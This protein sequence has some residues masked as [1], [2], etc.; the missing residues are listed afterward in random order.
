MVSIIVRR[1]DDG[2]VAS[3]DRLESDGGGAGGGRGDT[4]TLEGV[5]NWLVKYTRVRW[6]RIMKAAAP[7][8]AIMVPRALPWCPI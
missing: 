6:L 3:S 1:I 7:K 8:P 5:G 2:G 4:K